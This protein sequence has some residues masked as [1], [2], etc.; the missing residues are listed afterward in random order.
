MALELAHGIDGDSP[1]LEMLGD[2]RRWSCRSVFSSRNPTPA[3]AGGKKHSFFLSLSL[4]FF[5]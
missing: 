2:T 5:F 4:S 1:S 3:L